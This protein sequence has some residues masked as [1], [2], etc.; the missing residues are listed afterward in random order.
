MKIPI[1]VHHYFEH[2]EVDGGISFMEYIVMHYQEKG[3]HHD[4]HHHDLP[5]KA[6]QCHHFNQI[7]VLDFQSAA[8]SRHITVE[9]SVIPV[10]KE[11]FYNS[12]LLSSIWQPPQA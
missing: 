2:L 3:Q 10:Y 7:D 11:D 12:A 9:S 4:S 8:L 1:L 5:F 6:H